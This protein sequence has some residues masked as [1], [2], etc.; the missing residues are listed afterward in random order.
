MKKPT[1][2]ENPIYV[3]TV[4]DDIIREGLR[5]VA[6]VTTDL[7]A[8]KTVIEQKIKKGDIH[9]P[10]GITA[11]ASWTE[12]QAFQHDWASLAIDVVS[13]NLINANILCF[14]DGEYKGWDLH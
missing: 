14:G 12:V 1:D 2:I 6:M 8:L 10:K 7:N 11:P 3:L 9:Y 4:N 13:V 5:N